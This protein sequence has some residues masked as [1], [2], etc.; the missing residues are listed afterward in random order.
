MR[1]KSHREGKNVRQKHLEYLGT[2]PNTMK[3]P[4]DPSVAGLLAQAILSGTAPPDEMMDLLK[5]L[6]V[7]FSGKLK[8]LALIYNLSLR[9]LTLRI[10]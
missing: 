7:E 10:K 6:E 5:K 2:S 1:E 8:R 4:V 9:K 3:I